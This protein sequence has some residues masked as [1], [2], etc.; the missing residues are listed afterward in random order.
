MAKQNTDGN[1]SISRSPDCDGVIADIVLYDPLR[2]GASGTIF[3]ADF[4]V[5]HVTWAAAVKKF[6][7]PDTAKEDLFPKTSELRYFT[8]NNEI[9]TYKS[10]D[11]ASFCLRFYVG[12]GFT[13]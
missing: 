7:N 6:Y 9:K 4:K 2:G 13:A 5:G 11:D 12:V 3:N 8:L 10:L 1:G